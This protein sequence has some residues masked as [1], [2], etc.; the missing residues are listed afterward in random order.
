MRAQLEQEASKQHQSTTPASGESPSALYVS[1]PAFGRVA[2]RKLSPS[3]VLSLQQTLGNAAVC[4]MLAAQRR[5]VVQRQDDDSEDEY[6][7]NTEPETTQPDDSEAGYTEPEATQTDESQSEAEQPDDSQA[8]DTASDNEQPT[9]DNSSDDDTDSDNTTDDND[10]ADENADDS[11]A[12]GGTPNLQGTSKSVA[13]MTLNAAFAEAKGT[14]TDNPTGDL[15]INSASYQDLHNGTTRVTGQ[16]T[17]TFAANVSINLP[18][19]PADITDECEKGEY[20]KAINT[21]LDAHEKKHKQ[22][23]EQFDGSIKSSFN[24]VGNT[25][26]EG[27]DM[28]DVKA[29]LTKK[30]VDP[31]MDRTNAN[32]RLAKAEAAS[33]KI[34]PFTLNVDMSKCNKKP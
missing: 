12:D 11:D 14:A 29:A 1:T 23:Y 3:A 17:A 9:V 4:R 19:V 34:D 31:P 2:Q 7:A 10:N 20:Q 25:V 15:T 26:G 5:P 22:L 30:L 28:P 18:T 21:T 27:E 13:P 32:S 16:A 6:T 33:G 8:D 24:E